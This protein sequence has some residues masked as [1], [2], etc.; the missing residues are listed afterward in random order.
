MKT[1]RAFTLVEILIV[2]VILGILAATVM[3]LASG[4]TLSAK[5]SVVATDLQLLRNFILIYKAQHLEVAPGYPSGPA[6]TSTEQDFIN[7]ATL[8]STSAGATAA[9]GTSGYDRGPYMQ[10]IPANPLNDNK[11]TIKVVSGTNFPAADNTTGWVYLPELSQIRANS[12]GTDDNG[13]NYY[14]Y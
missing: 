11:R 1:A 10:L 9:I 8:S 6:S 2:V 4:T 13:K 7:Q 14:D 5:E 3:A 12:T